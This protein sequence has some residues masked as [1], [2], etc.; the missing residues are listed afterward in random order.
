MLPSLQ[1]QLTRSNT[2]QAAKISEL[3]KRIQTLE[4]DKAELA[5]QRDL[6]LKDVE[7]TGN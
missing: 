4:N 6:A 7:G 1:Y 2:V 5:K 3:E